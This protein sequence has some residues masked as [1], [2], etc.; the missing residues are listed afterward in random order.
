MINFCH[1]DTDCMAYMRVCTFNPNFTENP[2]PND[3]MDRFSDCRKWYK[4]QEDEKEKQKRR[5]YDRQ[6]FTSKRKTRGSIF[7]RPVSHNN[8]R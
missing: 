7:R 3:Y 1:G 6:D 8:I 5:Y 4:E 2:T